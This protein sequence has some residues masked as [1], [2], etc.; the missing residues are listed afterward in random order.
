MTC[1]DPARAN[2]CDVKK[3]ATDYH[4]VYPYTSFTS[5]P[6]LEVFSAESLWV[7]LKLKN[8]EKNGPS[9]SNI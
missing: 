5:S 6:N 3:S 9:A 8:V 7:P 1:Y 2:G 4:S